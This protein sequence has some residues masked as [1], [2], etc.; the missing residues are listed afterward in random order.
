[1]G[2]MLWDQMDRAGRIQFVFLYVLMGLFVLAAFIKPMWAGFLLVF[3]VFFG[4]QWYMEKL[5]KE[6]YIRHQ[7]EKYLY[8]NRDMGSG[9]RDQ[10]VSIIRDK[11]KLNI[12]SVEI[13]YLKKTSEFKGALVA[14]LSKDI[15]TNQKLAEQMY[16]ADD[17]AFDKVIIEKLEKEGINWKDFTDQ[18]KKQTGTETK[19]SVPPT[20]PNTKEAATTKAILPPT[21]II[22]K[23]TAKKEIT[24]EIKQIET[25]NPDQKEAKDSI[26]PEK[27]DKT[28]IPKDEKTIE[29]E[30][31]EEKEGKEIFESPFAAAGPINTDI[32]SEN[33]VIEENPINKE[34]PSEESRSDSKE[35]NKVEVPPIVT[36][37]PIQDFPAV[38]SIPLPSEEKGTAADQITTELESVPENTQNKEPLKDEPISKKSKPTSKKKKGKT[39]ESVE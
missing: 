12:Q 5:A 7:G 4:F 21:P 16:S 22:K 19:K 11:I 13:E 37:P 25:T 34:K 27:V 31:K 2:L 35:E 6:G 1:M 33:P 29:T 26:E 38:I 24:K 32:S 36:E 14:E 15:Q 9:D 3:A 23:T 18:S 30:S 28:E 17:Q 20:P 10:G 39:D 8:R